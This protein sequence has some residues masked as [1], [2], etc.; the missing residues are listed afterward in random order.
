MN[1]NTKLLE[2]LEE[3]IRAFRTYSGYNPDFFDKTLEMLRANVREETARAKGNKKPYKIIESMTKKAKKD[4]NNEMFQKA[5]KYGDKYGFL[6]GYRLFLSD[7]NYGYEVAEPERQFNIEPL[8]KINEELKSVE[9]DVADLRYYCKIYKTMKKYNKI[10]YIIRTADGFAAYNPEF[11]LDLIEYSGSNVIKYIK[12][13]AP[14]YSEN[15]DCLL[16]PVNRKDMTEE[17]YIQYRE[18]Y[19]VEVKAA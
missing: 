10:P 18:R 15:M 9:I 13:N 8:F 5:H 16:L 11:L 14:I 6:D 4:R 17:I 19:F 2:T 7:D 3:E 12:S 1:T